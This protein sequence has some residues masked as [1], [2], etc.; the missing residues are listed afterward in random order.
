[1][2]HLVSDLED[3]KQAYAHQPFLV[4]ET[5][6][7]NPTQGFAVQAPNFA[8]TMPSHSYLSEFLKLG[9]HLLQKIL[10]NYQGESMGFEET[11]AGTIS[12]PATYQ[13]RDFE[14]DI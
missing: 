7:I 8:K 11:A 4:C 14:E 13:V 1:M 12:S 3:F 5:A 2:L 10:K 9:Y 6:V